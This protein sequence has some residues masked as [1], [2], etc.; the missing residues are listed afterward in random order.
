MM[1]NVCVGGAC[2]LR[3][4]GFSGRKKAIS[5]FSSLN[6][7]TYVALYGSHNQHFILHK[8]ILAR[9]ITEPNTELKC[10]FLCMFTET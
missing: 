2:Q 6:A 3:V 8:V 5:P 4:P 7:T 1:L 10:Y 9:A